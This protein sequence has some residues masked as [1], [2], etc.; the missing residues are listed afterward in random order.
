MLSQNSAGGAGK[1]LFTI[2]SLQKGGKKK[3]DSTFLFLSHY[4]EIFSSS[5][6]GKARISLS[7]KYYFLIR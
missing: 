5:E 2:Y 7:E 6:Q 3:E 1:Y 4:L